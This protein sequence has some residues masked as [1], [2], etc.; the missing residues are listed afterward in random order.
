MN[1]KK[2]HLKNIGS[3]SDLTLAIAPTEQCSS[4]IT[5]IIGNNGAGKTIVL[6][7][8]S[9]ALSWLVAR[10]RSEK[11]AGSPI[12]IDN[13][14]N[15]YDYANI[16]L[17]LADLNWSLVKARAGKKAP[18]PSKLHDVTRLADKYRTLL[19]ENEHVSLPLISYYPVER[20][21]L[22]IPK[23]I[24][25]RHNFNQ[26]DGYDNSL[27]EGVDFRRFFEWFRA[28][29]DVEN[30]NSI[31]SEVL[32]KISHEPYFQGEI[33]TRSRDRELTAVRS[34]I[35]AFMLDFKYL[36]I[37]RTPLIH[38]V[39]D[40][41]GKTLDVDQL[42][43]GEKSLMALVGDIA[44]RLAMLNPALDNPLHGDGVVLIDEVDLHLHPQWQRKLINRLRSTF[45]NCQFILT[46]HAP[47]VISDAKNILCYALDNGE[48][49]E[50]DNLF[51]LDANEVLLGVM[52][53]DIRN[54]DVQ[55][56]L[57]VLLECIVES[58]NIQ[59]A[60]ILLNE[61]EA[62][63]SENN[64]ELIKARLLLHRLELRHAL[65]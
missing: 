5:V 41:N 8:I 60:K 29:E 51:G 57:D 1:I 22:D 43:Q 32:S 26:L 25:V 7:A 17:Y 54:A 46:T 19:T 23:R 13:I 64:L 11:G 3:F 14:K 6:H 62:E 65:H 49:S 40:K 12:K 28:R 47:L 35:Y 24:R 16:S 9:T 34:A 56:K 30:E 15:D 36:R 33:F 20:S 18:I 4:N 27:T 39:V 37:R 53:T 31:S 50:L 44:R 10:I 2:I 42:S 38:M 63:L 61:L 45:P 58:R 55:K 48:V 52:D 21:V 59:Q